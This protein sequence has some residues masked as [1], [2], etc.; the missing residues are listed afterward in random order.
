VGKT[1]RLEMSSAWETPKFDGAFLPEQRNITPQ[2]FTAKWD[3]YH[4]NRNFPQMW[5]GSTYSTEMSEF[6]VQLIIPVDHYQKAERSVKYAVVFIALTFFVFFLVELISRKRIHPLQ[7]L[8]V[9]IGLMLFYTLL[10]SLSE[11]VN[12]NLAY[13]VSAVAVV[14]LITGYSHVIFREV[15]QTALM[16]TF[17]TLLYVFLY[18]VLQLEDLALLIGS[19]GLFIALATIMYISRK[20]D[21]YH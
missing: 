21:W 1:T 9:S 20:V 10:L 15:K 11:H 8:L 19:I 18:T 5:E 6:G 17:F 13:F 3:V 7:Y 14:T 4:Y 12:F 16:G 2:G